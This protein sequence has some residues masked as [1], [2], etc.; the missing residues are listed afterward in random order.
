MTWDKLQS[1]YGALYKPKLESWRDSR[2]IQELSGFIKGNP[3]LGFFICVED[4][5]PVLHFDPPLEAESARGDAAERWEMAEV[6]ENLFFEALPD[7]EELLRSGRIDL[8]PASPAGLC[9]ILKGKGGGVGATSAGECWW[10]K[11]EEGEE[12]KD[13]DQG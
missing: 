7:I 6:A 11:E 10:G 4:G 3:E 12:V 9:G 1:K 13:G 8:P 2:R 5:R